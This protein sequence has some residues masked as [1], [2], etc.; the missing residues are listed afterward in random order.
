[1]EDVICACRKM[2]YGLFMISSIEG[3]RKNGQICNTLFQVTSDPPRM[4]AAINHKNLTHELI[5]RSGIFAATI[6]GSEDHRIVRRFGYRSGREFDK[7]KGV[8]YK[9]ARN[10]CP[11]LS[12]SVAYFECS[13]IPGM[14]VDAGTHSIFVAD[15]TGGGVLSGGEPMT[16]AHYHEV[17]KRQGGR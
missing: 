11:V 5:E 7:F 4:A 16:Y 3:D 12:G 9:E 1:M 6:L 8:E 17:R 15:I 14:T 10:G 2:P 13:V